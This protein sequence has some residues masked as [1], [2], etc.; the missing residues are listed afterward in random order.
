MTE[1]WK[2]SATRLAQQ[3]R[4]K[5]LSAREV[6]G[7][8]LERIAATNPT[9]NAITVVLNDTALEAADRVDQAIAS[10]Q[11]PGP[12]AGVPMT[13]K[14]N[15]DLAG[16][17]TTHGLTP[18]RDAIAA[19]TAPHLAELLDAGAIPIGR[20]NMPEF[21]MRWHTDNDRAGA[22]RNPHSDAHTP[23]GSSG[24]DAAAVAVGMTPLG[25]G[26]DGAGSLRW[27]AQC[28]GVVAL[29]PS[30]GRVATVSTSEPP[31]PMPFA[32]QLLASHGPMARDV[33][34]LRLALAHMSNRPGGDLFHV[35]APVAQQPPPKPI[36]V[37]VMRDAGG[38]DVDPNIE[39]AL[40][41]A[42]EHLTDAGYLVEE[43]KPP[44][45]N[46]GN[47]VYV[48]IM[49]RFG[50]TT[51]EAQRAPVGLVSEDFDRFWAALHGPWERAAGEPTHDPMMERAAIGHAWGGLMAETPLLLMPIATQ[52]P[53][54]VGSDLDET[55]CEQWLRSL[56][57]VTIVNLLGLPAVVVQTGMAAGLPQS[58]QIIGPRF[59]ED[60][61][62][63][64][65]QCIQ[66][67]VGSVSPIG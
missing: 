5:S 37:G 36:R 21:G 1:I 35:R 55:W 2:M 49:S 29:K 11:E 31:Q 47:E 3:V 38:L 19:H 24:G 25:I 26:N 18:L 7:A 51:A 8:H 52:P 43:R 20:T 16:S 56:R 45:L 42:A 67:R 54:L 27:P 63:D 57:M 61:C 44:L 28:C 15:Q 58:V 59:R 46:R 60:L 23:G 32:F 41:A 12:L 66:D 48:Q 30:Q 64:A 17:A 10:G 4:R 34:D 6:I 9:L 14:E 65:A 22:T 39:A 62:L 50:R 53:F 13:V 33:A 40:D